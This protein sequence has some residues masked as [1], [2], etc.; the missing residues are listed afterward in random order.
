[1]FCFDA[2]YYKKENVTYDFEYTPDYSSPF[3]NYTFEGYSHSYD[4]QLRETN[5]SL[6]CNLPKDDMNSGQTRLTGND[7]LNAPVA[8]ITMDEAIMAGVYV[9]NDPESA[10]A[11]ATTYLY[12]ISGRSSFGGLATMTPYESNMLSRNSGFGDVVTNGVYQILGYQ[13]DFQGET[14]RVGEYWAETN[15]V[16]NLKA[17]YAREFVWDATQNAYVHP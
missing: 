1:M 16:I 6:Y 8:T 15:P 14:W 10:G 5:P 12:D 3:L 7:G 11:I 4:A 9:L 2:N 13:G 17:D